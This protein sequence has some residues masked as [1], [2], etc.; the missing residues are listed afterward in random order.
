MRIL[1]AVLILAAAVAVFAAMLPN[2]A[3][4]ATLT[5]QWAML[6]SEGTTAFDGVGDLDGTLTDN[7][8]DPPTAD[9]GWQSP[10]LQF[11]GTESPVDESNEANANRIEGFSGALTHTGG[12]SL[13][14]WVT[15][16]SL[17]DEEPRFN[18]IFAQRKTG[19][20]P[21]RSQW[22]VLDGVLFG[23][24]NESEGSGTTPLALGTQYFVAWTFDGSNMRGYLDANE[25]FV[26]P[27]RC[28]F[29]KF[30]AS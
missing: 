13:T 5:H 18:V 11:G 14:A 15:A 29:R 24:R 27:T 9:S 12:F 20:S 26:Q 2:D 4:A 10:G 8:D 6:E 25:E 17:F 28:S 1:S 7:F 3:A 22:G 30:L 16:D 23:G 19:N 21:D